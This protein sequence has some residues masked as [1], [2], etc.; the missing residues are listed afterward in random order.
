ML[1]IAIKTYDS[2]FMI[3]KLW[4]IEYDSYE[5]NLTWQPKNIEL[6]QLGLSMIPYV[7]PSSSFRS[8]YPILKRI[9]P[10]NI[11]IRKNHRTSEQLFVEFKSWKV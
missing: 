1:S 6:N 3:H 4:L 7:N 5:P 8:L 11:R 10:D 2:Y 9:I